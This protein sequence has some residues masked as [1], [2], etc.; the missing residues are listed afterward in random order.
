MNTSDTVAPRSAEW[1]EELRKSRT[2]RERGNI[3]R[4]VMPELTPEFCLFFWFF[5]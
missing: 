5:F 4:T 1:R 3:A 2:A